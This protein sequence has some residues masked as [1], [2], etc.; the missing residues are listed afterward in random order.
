LEQAKRVNA[1][2][3]LRRR[4]VERSDAA[5]IMMERYEI[6][7]RQ[8]YR[9]L[10]GVERRRIPVAIPEIKGVFTVKLPKRLVLRIRRVSRLGG[11]TLSAVVA[12]ALEYFL[13][14]RRK[15]V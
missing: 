5:R 4:Y 8:A 7:R 11:M 10:R 9:Y 3:V 14:S 6:S 1:A 12:Q 2:L 15:H 13:R